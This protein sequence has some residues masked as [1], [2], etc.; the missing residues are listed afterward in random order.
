MFE[1]QSPENF[2]QKCLCVIVADVSGSMQGQPLYQLNEGLQEFQ[3]EI[4]QDYIASQRLEIAVVAFGSTIKVVQEPALVNNFNMPTLNSE[5]STKL[6][7]AVRKAVSIV[8]ERKNWYRNTGQNYYRP[9]IV[10][11]TDGEPD[12]DQDMAGLSGEIRMSVESKKFT[13][14]SLGVKGY[15]HS[16]LAGICPSNTP[17]LPL[18]GYKFSE[19]FKWLSNSISVIAK[20]KEGE[21]LALPP[22]TGWTQIQM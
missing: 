10:L 4:M 7:D 9:F 21:F 5:G 16:K 8:D 12:P 19:F 1:G 13:F 17:P 2:E 22:A 11:I 14:W 6:V 18:D 3:R 20:S 15:N